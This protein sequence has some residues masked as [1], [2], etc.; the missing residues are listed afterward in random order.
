MA[1]ATHILAV[2]QGTTSSRAIARLRCASGGLALS[3]GSRIR[4]ERRTCLN[5]M[6]RPTDFSAARECVKCAEPVAAEACGVCGYAV[7]PRKPASQRL[8]EV[9]SLAS[10]LAL[11][12]AVCRVLGHLIGV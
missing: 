12:V 2:D 11:V 3:V 1:N 10:A 6:T 7:R 4:G 5:E 8:A 9:A